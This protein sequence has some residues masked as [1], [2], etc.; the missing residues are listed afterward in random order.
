MLSV[1]LFTGKEYSFFIFIIFYFQAIPIN[2]KFV[3]FFNH[4]TLLNLVRDITSQ[5]VVTEE[6][7]LWIKKNQ[8]IEINTRFINVDLKIFTRKTLFIR[9]TMLGNLVNQHRDSR[10]DPG[11]SRLH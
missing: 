2:D 8:I 1:D 4:A 7:H 5:P 3:G 11:S 10:N 9:I 6:Y